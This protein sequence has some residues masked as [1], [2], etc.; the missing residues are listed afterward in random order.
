MSKVTIFKDANEVTDPKYISLQSA[1]GRIKEGKS[2]ET[3]E[4]IRSLPKDSD[5]V[6]ELKKTLPSVVFGGV[7]GRVGKTKKGGDTYRLDSCITEHSGVFIT[8]FD[9][10]DDPEHKKEQLRQDPY[11][12]AA[13]V[14]PTLGVK[15][16]VRCPP[17]IQN[18]PLYYNAFLDR[19][20]ELDPTSKNIGRLCFE[21]YDPDIYI[22]MEGLIWDKTLTDEEYQ[23]SKLKRENRRKKKIL[24]IAILM[25][26]KSVKGERHNV[27]LKAA[28]LCGGYSRLFK[29][30][31][32]IRILTEEVKAKGFPIGE[33]PTETKAVRDGYDHGKLLPIEDLKEIE[34]E[35][36]FTR[37]ADG[38]YDF[39]A[40]ESEMDEYEHQVIT[41]TL[42]MGLPTGLN[43]LNDW[44]MFKKNTLVWWAGR[45]NT[46][47]SFTV[48]YLA[49]LS[50]VLYGWKIL[51]YSKEN[52][53]GQVRKKIKEFYIG[54]SIK[55]FS[56]E[57]MN[58]A[59]DFV[60]KHFRIMTARKMHTAQEF[61]LK[62]EMV[63]DEGWEYDLLIAEPYNA[64][65][66]PEG[67]NQYS[68]NVRVLNFLQTFKENYSAVWVCDH[69]NT[70]AARNKRGKEDGGGME[71]PT[72]HDVEFGQNKP[73]KSDD[74]IILHRDTKNEEKRYLTEIHVEKIKDFETGGRPTFKDSPVIIQA[75]PDLCGF[76][77]GG[78]D[79][80]KSYWGKEPPAPKESPLKT[81]GWDG[82]RPVLKIIET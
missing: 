70:Q 60:N 71:V 39:M 25:I 46:G 55:L 22:R 9:G 37:R 5:E 3:V 18:H 57:E 7:A 30:D 77:C 51:V 13:W 38:T 4:K 80:I 56:E 17:N 45:D 48:W 32:A 76:S 79:P 59:N 20:P 12:L 65:D 15:A 61:L 21:S 50:A 10:V 74:F 11:I 42:E 58:L 62:C 8:D 1:L 14:S 31:E 54:K 36:D 81:P 34:K 66:V 52:R 33:L 47:K 40:D 67:A 29:G 68:L 41:G 72:K 26:R 44:W 63:Y 2:K 27:I 28:T 6:G 24:D 64:F 49:T 23:E 78:V 75:N 69:I 16:L 43:Q 53:D 73:N 19:Y 82:P 35:A